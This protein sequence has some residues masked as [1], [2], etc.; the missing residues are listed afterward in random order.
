MI[1]GGVLD[2]MHLC[3]RS[4]VVLLMAYFDMVLF[5]PE[6]QNL[7]D[8]P[9]WKD[10]QTVGVVLPHQDECVL[11]AFSQ[12]VSG[13]PRDPPKASSEAKASMRSFSI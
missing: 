10:S 13:D 3:S 2:C 7:P 5:I 4:V 11:S 1:E 6:A 8:F 9:N 12:S